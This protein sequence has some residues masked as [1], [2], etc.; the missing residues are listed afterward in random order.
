MPVVNR[1]VVLPVDR[2]RAWELIT[3]PSELEGWLADEVE[4]EAEEDA[5]L[6]VIDGGEREGVV[7]EVTE[8]SGSSSAGATRASSGRSRTHPAARASSSPS[9]ASPPTRSPGAR[10]GSW[11]SPRASAAVPGV[12]DVFSALADPTRREVLRSRRPAAGADRLAAGRRAADHPPGRRQAPR[13]LQRAGLVEPRREGRE[14]RYTLTPAPLV[15][16]MGWMA[17]V[18]G[19]WTSASHRLVERAA[20]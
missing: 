20:R 17:E 8:A 12:D 1:E 19:L 15:D 18:G 9:T 6:R 11:R 13:A 7:E 4:F 2:E 10:S 14:T 3:E 5:P 16:A